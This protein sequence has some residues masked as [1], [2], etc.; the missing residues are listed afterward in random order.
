MRGRLVIV[1]LFAVALAAGC[2]FNP[3]PKDGRLSCSEGC[4]SGYEC[5]ADNF[6]YRTSA[7]LAD[8]GSDSAII[9]T[10]SAAPDL[11]V[12]G[13]DGPLAEAGRDSSADSS[14]ANDVGGTKD[15]GSTDTGSADTG[16]SIADAPIGA[17]GAGGNSDASGSGDD[18]GTGGTRS[19]AG[20]TTATGG[21][22]GSG[23]TTSTGGTGAGGVLGGA[24][25]VTNAG[26]NYST[27]GNHSTGGILATGGASSM[28]GGTEPTGGISSAGGIPGTGGAAGST[29]PTGGTGPAGGTSNTGGI[30]MGGA[31]ADGGPGTGGA[32]AATD[33]PPT[34][35]T[36]FFG[37]AVTSN[38][39]LFKA[40]SPYTIS[41]NIEVNS[42][43]VLTIE[44]GVT[45]SFAG[46]FGLD[47]GS[48]GAGE[49]VAVGTAQNLITLTS[50]ASPPLPGDWLDIHLW[51]G[52][53][54]GTQIAYAKVDYC[55]ADRSGCIV[56]DG[57]QPTRVTIDHVTVD[58]VGPS[59][60]GILEHDAASNFV[61]TNS[62]FSSI[63]NGQYA[64]SVQAS[65]FAGIGAGNTFKGGTMIEI[66]GGTISS[67][68]SWVDPGTPVAVTGSVWL[69][70]GS[71]NPVLTISAGM[72]LMFAAVNPPVEFSVGYGGAGSLVIAGTSAKRVTLTSR[73]PTPAPGDWVGVEVWSAGNAQISFADI[74]YAG[75]DGVS[76]GGDLI[77]EN[78]NSPADIAVDHSS[79]TYSRGYGIYLDCAGAT[80]TQSTVELNAGITYAHNESD[81]TNSGLP[82][83][84]VGPGLTG[85]DCTFH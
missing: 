37:G 64:I 77:L 78:G 2:G 19:G 3:H 32:D 13:A 60:D 15:A 31:A 27:G 73:A 69:E 62:T 53:M 58:H 76:G 47:V 43:A 65:S 54:S 81:P 83:D 33:S 24:G 34:A 14:R 30:S 56:G 72:T 55:G 23:G 18:S 50:A 82:S 52:T 39:T 22:T 35:C 25:G 61:I 57:V 84:N 70:S 42:G 48:S 79:F 36:P 63:P 85:P 71:G 9:R 41:E 67:T 17:G 80:I 10:D 4:P 44:P 20:G 5:R 38:L 11:G 45:L 7:P 16:S 40:C 21:M 75:S 68:T 29:T 1:A 8:S 66:G 59:S 49:L 6:C 26:G 12:G 51:G 28:G 74:S 46:S